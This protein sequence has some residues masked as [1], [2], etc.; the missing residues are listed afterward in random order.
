MSPSVAGTGSTEGCSSC[1]VS[2]VRLAGGCPKPGGI[3]EHQ[4]PAPVCKFCII[5]SSPSL[6]WH[7][8]GDQALSREDDG[9]KGTGETGAACSRRQGS[10]LN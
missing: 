8:G 3:L 5:P 9:R 7:D 2:G 6:L 1:K 10:L 4:L